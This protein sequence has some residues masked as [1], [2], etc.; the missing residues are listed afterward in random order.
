MTDEGSFSL[1]E[2]SPSA[3]ELLPELVAHLREKRGANCARSGRGASP[4]P[5][6]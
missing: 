1:Q 5:A 2:T 3:S 4:T 6:C